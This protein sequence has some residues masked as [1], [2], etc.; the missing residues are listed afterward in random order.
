METPL[1]TF[2]CSFPIKVIGL[3]N[4]QFIQDTTKIIQSYS[5][6]FNP[7]KDMTAKL[8]NKNNYLALNITIEAESQEQLDK[9]YLELNQNKLVKI[10]L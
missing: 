5:K 6:N 1:L 4:S 10:T 8:S 7:D 9:I 3:N 2:P